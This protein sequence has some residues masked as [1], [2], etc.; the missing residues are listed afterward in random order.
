MRSLA[1]EKR[2]GQS[3]ALVSALRQVKALLTFRTGELRIE[4]LTVLNTEV[5]PDT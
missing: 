1:V 5:P 3:D 4:C 2:T